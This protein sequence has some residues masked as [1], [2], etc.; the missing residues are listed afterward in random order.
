METRT[1]KIPT[2]SLDR[3]VGLST[4]NLFN[5]FSQSWRKRKKKKKKSIQ[6]NLYYAEQMETVFY[7][8][9]WPK[10]QMLYSIKVQKSF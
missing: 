6:N 5:R 3:F 2:S 7:H 8:H 10:P 4:K 9:Q 1:V